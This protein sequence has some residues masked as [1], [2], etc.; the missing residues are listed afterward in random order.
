MDVRLPDGTI[1]R[2]VP[3]GTTKAQIM[4]KLGRSQPAEAPLDPTEGM[5]GTDKFLAGAGK[6]FVDIGRGVKQMLGMADQSEIDEARRMDAPLMKTGYGVAGNVLG[7]VAAAAPSMFIPGANS[8]GGAAAV[9]GVLNA[10]QPTAADESRLKNAALGAATGGMAQY[11]LGKIAGMAG[12]R[13]AGQEAAGAAEASQNAV[14]D[15]TLKASQGAGYVVPPSQA[16]AGVGPRILEGISGK[17][18][19]NQAAA[20]KN[21][22]VTDRLARQALGLTDDAPITRETMQAVR[23]RAFQQGYEPVVNFGAVETDTT[24]K[25]SLDAIVKDYQGAARSFQ[26]ARAK[27][28]H[29]PGKPEVMQMVDGLR[30]SAFDTGDALAMTRILR[31]EV[32]SAYASGNT[33]LGKATKKAANAIED[34]IERALES[35]GK[36]GAE[37]LKAFR[38]ARILMAKTHSVEKALVEGGGKVNAKVLGAALQ[39]GKP[40]SGELRTIGA[41]ANNF[42]DVAGVPQSGFANPI[43]ALDAFGTAGMAGLGA[44][45]MSLALPAARVGSRA[46]ILSGPVQKL[47]VGPQYGP[48][49]L[50]RLTPKMLEELEKRGMG[51]LL[52]ASYGAQ[53]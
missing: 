45:P 24:F 47:F 26:G 21:Q 50:N 6:G 39:R 23:D 29:G 44:G 20:I 2:N 25:R 11:G 18:K 5:S 27:G 28:M 10:L 22:N 51:G 41:F 13:L 7:T 8:V 48:G 42:K 43:T 9:G 14:R 38:D 19:T 1:I 12:K 15:A 30:T 52:G 40:L 4:T 34:Q 49:L 16:G 46:A 32:N 36:D 53:Q 31:D 33:A 17:F 35:A 3:E 37:M